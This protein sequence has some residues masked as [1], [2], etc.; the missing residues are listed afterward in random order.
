MD[1]NIIIGAAGFLLICLISSIS[2]A[3]SGTK[4]ETNDEEL[5]ILRL[6]KLLD[7]IRDLSRRAG[8]LEELVEKATSGSDESSSAEFQKRQGAWDQVDYGWGGGRFGKRQ[9]H[10]KRYDMY[11][12]SGRFGRDV[13]R[14]LLDSGAVSSEEQS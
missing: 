4:E 3:P 6:A 5:L 11:G 12:M 2:G 14:A 13:S 8:A 7:P 10:G 9:T 1:R